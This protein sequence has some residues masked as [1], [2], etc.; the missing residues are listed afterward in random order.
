[1]SRYPGTFAEYMATPEKRGQRDAMLAMCDE[2]E[3]NR[4]HPYRHAA[5]AD[6]LVRI[7]ERCSIVTGEWVTLDPPVEIH[8]DDMEWLLQL[9]RDGDVL[10][11]EIRLAVLAA[12][13]P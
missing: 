2:Y 5:D 6:G 7:R 13:A 4:R 3:E 11:Y 1:M 10:D 8:H 9:W 12:D